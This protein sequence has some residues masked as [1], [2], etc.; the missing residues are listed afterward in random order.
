MRRESSSAG[1]IVRGTL[2]GLKALP[3]SCSRSYDNK[4]KHANKYL[5]LNPSS[6]APMPKT[7]SQA[8]SLP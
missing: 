5:Q 3:V 2:Q 6:T 8:A 4:L 7:I 1:K